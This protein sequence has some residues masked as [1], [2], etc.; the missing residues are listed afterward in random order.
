MDRIAK[1]GKK[2]PR[3]VGG[4]FEEGIPAVYVEP[5]TS[6]K[7]MGGGSVARQGQEGGQEFLKLT[8]V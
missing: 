2:V 8:A 6:G 3:E 7:K 5:Q 1:M 4:K